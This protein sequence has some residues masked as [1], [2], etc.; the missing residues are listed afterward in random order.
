MQVRE[1]LAAFLKARDIG[2]S[3]V[4]DHP[5]DSNYQRQFADNLGQIA[6]C[7]CRLGRHQDETVVRPLAI[8]HA[9]IAYEKAAQVLANG[10]LY[11]HLWYR[12]GDNLSSQSRKPEAFEAFRQA[13]EV[14]ATLARENPVAPDLV[15]ELAKLYTHAHLLNDVPVESKA[16]PRRDWVDRGRRD[17]GSLPGPRALFGLARIL[18]LSSTLF[19]SLESSDEGRARRQR[20]ADLA[21]DALKRAIAAGY[22][23]VKELTGDPLLAALAARDDFKTLV[24]ELGR[25]GA[26]GAGTVVDDHTELDRL[27]ASLAASQHAIG[28]IQFGLGDRDEARKSLTEAISLRWSLAP[29]DPE[30]FAMLDSFTRLPLDMDLNDKLVPLLERMFERRPADPRILT[31][32]GRAYSA[33]HRSSLKAGRLAQASGSRKRADDLFEELSRTRPGDADVAAAWAED[34]LNLGNLLSQMAKPEEALEPYRKVL[35]I[36]RNLPDAYPANTEVQGKS[37]G[38]HVK[39]GELLST[40]AR[41]HEALKNWDAA[42]ADWSRAATGNPDEAKILGEFARRLAAGGQAPLAKAQFAKSQAVYERSL[43]ADPGSDLVAAELAQVLWDQHGSEN[44]GR[45]TVLK[46]TEMKSEGGATLTLQGDGSILASGK[47][48][49]RDAYTLV[50]RPG[51]EQITAIRLEALPDP[52]LPE[53]GPGR[54]AGHPGTGNF[55]LNELSVFSRGKRCTLTDMIV[56]Y[57]EAQQFRNVIDG[58]TDETVGWSNGMRAGQKNSAIVATHVERAPDDDLKIEM[59][60]SRSRYREHNLGRFRLSVSGDPA[61]LDQERRR[62]AAVQ[63][64]DPWQKLAAAYQ[65]NGEPQAIDRLVERL[66]KLAGPIGDLFTQ[67]KDE[68]KDWRRAIALYSKGITAETTDAL[69]FSKRARAHE[70]LENWEAAAADWSRASSGNPDGAKLLVEFAR[71]LAAFGQASLSDATRTKALALFGEKRVKEIEN[72]ALPEE[73][74][75]IHAKIEL[76]LR[77]KQKWA[78]VEPLYRECLAIHEKLGPDHPDTV[79]SMHFLG[80]VCWRM[81]QLDKSIPLFEKQLKIQEAKLGR[82]HPDSLRSVANLGVNYMDAGRLKEAMPLL[83]EAFQGAKK[84]PSLAWVHQP[85]FVALLGFDDATAAKHLAALVP[86]LR[87]VFGENHRS[88]LTGMNNFGYAL[89][90]TRRF[91]EAEAMLKDTIEREVR[92]LGEGDMLLLQTRTN[93]GEMYQLQGRHAE[94]EELLRKCLKERGEKEPNSF[95]LASTQSM[96]GRVLAE[97]KKFAEAESL[98]LAGY[99]GLKDNASTT[100]TWGKYYLPNTLDWLTQLHEAWGRPE[101]AT[102][103]RVL[104]ANFPELVPPSSQKN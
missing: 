87:T 32:I 58:R 96:L 20:D 21:T 15:D 67:G 68:D 2:A 47:N 44:P 51:L 65:V 79:K 100:P 56:A 77:Q 24:T 95:R 35:A 18:A 23:N 45:W 85:L 1:A 19:Y 12:Q 42:L 78:E 3:L 31:R 71:R 39:I 53:N 69:L 76:A 63:L 60:F 34:Q 17:L 94:A 93:L 101:E 81:R 37:A 11:A 80:V 84:A 66:P 30:N 46:P 62:S 104:R 27:R 29:D 33:L 7:L 75:D 28:L 72:P 88:T 102:K 83:E 73:L 92:T 74:T 52:S 36:L 14:Y 54:F 8:E 26:A 6:E 4:G 38:S 90:R 55:H 70:A 22:R 97:E 16:D 50:A 86:T 43:K 103:W 82:D 98:L 48:P 59:Y 40:R 64:T 91:T 99:K 49:E 57:D 10:R 13:A 61:T 25:A 9:R 41:A 89:T 5:G